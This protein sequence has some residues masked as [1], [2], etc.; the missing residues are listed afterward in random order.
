MANIIEEIIH[1][2]FQKG[3]AKARLVDCLCLYRDQKISIILS[4]IVGQKYISS[5]NFQLIENRKENILFDEICYFG[6]QA[7]RQLFRF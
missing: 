4:K 5:I 1:S 7:L 2:A 3:T 6:G